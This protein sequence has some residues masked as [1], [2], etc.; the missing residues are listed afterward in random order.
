MHKFFDLQDAIL[1]ARTFTE[2]STVG[3]SD[4]TTDATTTNVVWFLMPCDEE[5]FLFAVFVVV[6][7]WKIAHV[8]HLKIP[9]KKSSWLF[10]LQ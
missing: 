1:K 4:W 10:T 3:E 9:Q 2:T 5:F 7:I 8:F 6:K